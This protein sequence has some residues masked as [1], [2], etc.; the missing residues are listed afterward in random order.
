M[1]HSA[2]HSVRSEDNFDWTVFIDLF[3]TISAIMMLMLGYI[4]YTKSQ[5]DDLVKETQAKIEVQQEVWSEFQKKKVSFEQEKKLLN[6]DVE[7]LKAALT[8]KE[9]LLEQ[10]KSEASNLK[11]ERNI[12]FNDLQDQKYSHEKGLKNT[13]EALHILENLDNSD[14]VSGEIQDRSLEELSEGLVVLSLY[15]NNMKR[16]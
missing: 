15:S 7:A 4:A 12:L 8:A 3:A 2:N 10:Y 16:S 11:R 13:A 6:S 14:N 5:S 1:Y 9:V